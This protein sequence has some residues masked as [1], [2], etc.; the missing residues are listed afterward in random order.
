MRVHVIV[1]DADPLTTEGLAASLR[2]EPR[3]AALPSMAA[4]EQALEQCRQH[5]PAVLL[6][7]DPWLEVIDLSVFCQSMDFGRPVP[8]VV[9]GAAPDPERALRCLRLGCMGYVHRRDNLATLRQAV[10]AV[11]AG[12]IWA[13]RTTLTQLLRQ[14]ADSGDNGRRLTDRESQILGLIASGC[15]N[16]EI[17]SRLFIS[18]E[19]VRWHVRRVFAKIGARDRAAAADYARHRLLPLPRGRPPERIPVQAARWTEDQTGG[20]ATHLRHNSLA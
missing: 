9:L 7:S 12:Q 20:I 5:L 3:L 19:T 10:Y 16:G 14:F 8:V 1:A 2:E 18:P 4:P 13:P 6:L 17:S 15:A 11:A